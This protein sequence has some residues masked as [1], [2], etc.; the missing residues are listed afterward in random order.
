MAFGTSGGLEKENRSRELEPGRPRRPAKLLPLCLVINTFSATAMKAAMLAWWSN[1]NSCSSSSNA[2]LA[3][4]PL[5]PLMK[6]P[7]AC[8][9]NKAV[10]CF[11]PRAHLAQPGSWSSGGR[12][13]G[14]W[15]W[16]RHRTSMVQRTLCHVLC[17]IQFHG[18]PP[19][20]CKG[21]AARTQRA[22]GG[23]Q[24]EHHLTWSGHTRKVQR[25]GWRCRGARGARATG[26][27][28]CE[29][30]CRGKTTSVPGLPESSRLKESA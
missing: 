19:R 3:P 16:G 15:R 4:L 11:P 9:R 13:A 23:N 28:I 27:Q 6:L 22:A 30:S 29:K 12:R 10:T 8:Q 25:R 20:E 26:W 21:W 17:Q 1:P 2:R 24:D 7:V 18:P 5:A 14:C